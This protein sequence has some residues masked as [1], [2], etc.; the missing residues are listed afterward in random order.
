M[1]RPI[2]TAVAALAAAALIALAAPSAS[3]TTTTATKFNNVQIAEG[4]WLESPTEVTTDVST[5]QKLEQQTVAGEATAQIQQ[6]INPNGSS[7]WPA[8]RGVIP[9]QF[10][11]VKSDKVQQRTVTTTTTTVTKAPSFKSIGTDGVQAWYAANYND[12]SILTH[13]LPANSTVADIESLMASYTW[14]TGSNHG[15]SLRWTIQAE[16]GDFWA[17]YGTGPNFTDNTG[18]GSGANLIEQSDERFDASVRGGPTYATW[19]QIEALYGTEK[20]QYVSLILDGGWGGDQEINLLSADV[21]TS[22]RSDH[23][24]VADT[25]TGGLDTANP[26][27]AWSPGNP[28]VQSD[29]PAWNT[30]STTAP[31]ATNDVPA[32]LVVKKFN[33]GQTVE[34]VNEQLSSAQGDTGG[35]FRQIDGKYMYNLKVESLG[36]LPGDYKVYLDL[37]TD[38][39]PPLENAPGAFSLK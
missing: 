26:W 11:L 39:Q 33:D 18:P 9:V 19:S 5:A 34:F 20:V 38:G 6:P 17:Y 30:V 8:K 13:R 37:D 22:A 35:Q 29:N 28:H 24:D 4:W 36:S 12:S 23:V 2:R 14:I 10:K 1:H 25:Y 7:T 27:D 31:V 3:A 32:H 15:G 21:S 16:H